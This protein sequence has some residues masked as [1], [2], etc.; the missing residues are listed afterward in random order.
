MELQPTPSYSRGGGGEYTVERQALKFGKVINQMKM[1]PRQEHQ[2]LSCL[3][4]Q[5]INTPLIILPKDGDK[6]YELSRY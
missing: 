3:H 4:K 2:V 5:R 1:A 6:V